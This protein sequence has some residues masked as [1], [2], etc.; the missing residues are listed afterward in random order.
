[1]RPIV[2]KRAVRR[3][4]N[5][6]Q[7]WRKM[8]EFLLEFWMIA[9][10]FKEGM[11]TYMTRSL[12]RLTVMVPLALVATSAIL[13]FSP[14]RAW[15]QWQW[16]D[17]AGRP[18]F[19]DL[20]PPKDIPPERIIARPD[21]SVRSKPAPSKNADAIA[22]KPANHAEATQNED[23]HNASE[24]PAAAKAAKPSA[25]REDCARARNMLELLK[26]GAKTDRKIAAEYSKQIPAMEKFLRE[27]CSK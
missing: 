2:T 24:Q 8:R 3:C 16:T 27:E 4:K 11:K 9:H 19:S 22:E 18:V 10:C 26:S 17:D 7:G 23:A 6:R 20:P 1:M 13:A 14:A 25:Q 21:L 15:A 12:N 5:H